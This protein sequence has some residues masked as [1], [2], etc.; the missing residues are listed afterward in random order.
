MPFK[1]SQTGYAAP[2]RDGHDHQVHVVD[3]VGL[4][5]LPHDRRSFTDTDVLVWGPN[6]RH[7]MI[8]APM[9]WLHRLVAA[10]SG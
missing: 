4:Q 3:Q 8:S 2:E 1:P 5:K 6:L 9:P 7:P 10:R